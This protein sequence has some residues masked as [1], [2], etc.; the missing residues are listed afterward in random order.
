MKITVASSVN[1]DNHRFAHARKQLKNRTFHHAQRLT[2]RS[3][4]SAPP[5]WHLFHFAA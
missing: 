2:R 1:A 3:P 5:P 4:D